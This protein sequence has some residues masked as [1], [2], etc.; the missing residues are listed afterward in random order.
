MQ[1]KPTNNAALVIPMFGKRVQDG[2]PV[3]RWPYIDLWLSSIGRQPM[4]V[5]F[6]TDYDTIGPVPSN[7]KVISMEMDEIYDRAEA[8]FDIKFANRFAY[9]LCDLKSFY[10]AIFHEELHPYD[11]WGY[12][13]CDVLYGQLPEFG[14]HD[15]YC[16]CHERHDMDMVKSKTPLGR[17]FIPGHFVMMRNNS[18]SRDI[19][20]YLPTAASLLAEGVNRYIDEHLTP[21]VLRHIFKEDR[22]CEIRANDYQYLGNADIQIYD[23]LLSINGKQAHYIHFYKHKNQIITPDWREIPSCFNVRGYVQES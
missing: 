15:L 22:R 16:G 6:I 3:I 19:F 10:G 21:T 18:A 2:K 12:G 23:G 7:V 9:K 1:F 8:A 4:D 13:D 17:W 14:D 11:F 20:G 5:L